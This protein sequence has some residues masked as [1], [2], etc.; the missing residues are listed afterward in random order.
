[1]RGRGVAGGEK[2]KSATWFAHNTPFFFQR[3]VTLRLVC[4]VKRRKKKKRGKETRQF[5]CVDASLRLQ[6][7]SKPPRRMCFSTSRDVIGPKI[8]NWTPLSL[9]L[10]L[11]V[12]LSLSLTFF[13]VFPFI[14]PVLTG[15]GRVI[16]LEREGG[17]LQ[18][19]KKCMCAGFRAHRLPPP[20]TSSSCSP[21][22][23]C[24]NALCAEGTTGL[25]HRGTEDYCK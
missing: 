24:L 18:G 17:G 23:F 19:R 16:I 13:F 20:P 14:E 22:S 8:Q 6:T 3:A 10:F 4:K 25:R 5:E 21:P 12:S 2:N 15:S 11:S 1:M 7:P 9:S